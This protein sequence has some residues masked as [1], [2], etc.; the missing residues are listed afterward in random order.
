MR[1]HPF[2][3]PLLLTAVLAAA[4]CSSTSGNAAG[5]LGSTTS[6]EAVAAS[7]TSSSTT[8]PSTTAPTTTIV[9]TTIPATPQP[10]A[11]VA[12]KPPP[13][14]TPLPTAPPVASVGSVAVKNFPASVLCNRD[15]QL[16]ITLTFSASNAAG[17]AVWSSTD[18]NLGQFPAEFGEAE[19]PY[20]C[21]RSSYTL[22]PVALGG[23]QGSPVDYFVPIAPR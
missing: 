15:E 17:V 10:A 3:L 12:P 19:V 14:A 6:S 22:W 16:N 5:A 8:S 18:G 20:T 21:E 23:E 13:A 7:T 2:V 9:T 1:K 4:G 11:T